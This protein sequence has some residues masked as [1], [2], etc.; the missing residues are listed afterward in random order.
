MWRP[1]S[2]LFECWKP[3]PDERFTQQ[4]PALIAMVTVCKTDLGLTRLSRVRVEHFNKGGVT[5]ICGFGQIELT[6]FLQERKF[7]AHT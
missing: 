3:R 7:C 4:L 5:P 1:N 6:A 2:S